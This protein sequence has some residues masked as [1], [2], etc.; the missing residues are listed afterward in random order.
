MDKAPLVSERVDLTQYVR[1]AIPS[2]CKSTFATFN[3]TR[4]YCFHAKI[5]IECAQ[6]TFKAEFSERVAVLAA[7]YDPGEAVVASSS[8]AIP[9]RVE[10]E[11]VIPAYEAGPTAPPT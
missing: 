4:D 3:I 10:D 1:I 8:T 5:T 2:Y 6:K 9:W 7:T 11:V